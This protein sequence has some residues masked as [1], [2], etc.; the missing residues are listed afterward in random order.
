[1]SLQQSAQLS[2]DQQEELKITIGAL[3]NDV[4]RVH[5][6]QKQLDDL[7][8]QN[9]QLKLEINSRVQRERLLNL[10]IVGVPKVINN[11]D[12]IDII[13]KIAKKIGVDITVADIQNIN[14]VSPKVKIQAR[15]KVI[16]AKMRSRLLKDNIISG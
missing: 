8:L 1:M 4:N 6:L 16:V 14:R 7:K 2:S 5:Q 3:S 15:P 9:A 10:E 12:L 11:E 13:C